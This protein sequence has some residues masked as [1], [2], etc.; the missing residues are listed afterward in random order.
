MVLEQHVRWLTLLQRVQD[1]LSRHLG[2]SLVVLDAECNEVTVPSGLPPI[3]N[4]VN[5]DR[6]NRCWSLRREAITRIQGSRQAV[7]LPCPKGRCC[8]V[9]PAGVD[10]DD[11]ET[12]VQYVVAGSGLPQATES[13]R[14]IQDIFRVVRPPIAPAPAARPAASQPAPVVK[15]AYG[16][17][18]KREMEILALIGAGLS[19]REIAKQLYVSQSTVKTHI[20]HLLLKLGLNNRTEAALY[21][22][23]ESISSAIHR[24]RP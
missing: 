7:N 16:T 19:N 12:P 20:T 13:M 3:C 8:F 23:R 17:L 11:Y 5:P 6:S 15:G 2:F 24:D 18:T 1:Q 4:T 21:A 22:A 10:D 14:L 9:S